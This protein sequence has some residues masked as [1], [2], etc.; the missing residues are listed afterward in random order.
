MKWSYLILDEGHRIKNADCQLS[1]MLQT[2]KIKHRLLLTG[3]PVH[4]KL[5]E[6]WSL[7]HFLVC[8]RIMQNGLDPEYLGRNRCDA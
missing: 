4:N 8:F 3:T 7:L 6:L 2:Y 1:Q 5:Q